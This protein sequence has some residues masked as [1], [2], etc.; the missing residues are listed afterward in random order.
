[1]TEYGTIKIPRDEYEKHN[2]RRQDM[3][4]TWA[5]YLNSEP[6]SGLS[7]DMAEEIRELRKG[8]E[9][10]ESRTG[11]IERELEQLEP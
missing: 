8:I 4:L 5:E 6:P 3:G 1:M 11:R 2:E 9:T 10:V 7:E